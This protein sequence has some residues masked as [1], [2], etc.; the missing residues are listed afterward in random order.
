MIKTENLKPI[1]RD[2]AVRIIT[3]EIKSE[4]GLI[5]KTDKQNEDIKLFEV[6]SVSPKVTDVSVGDKVY[7]PWA[8]VTLPVSIDHNGKETRVG[9]TSEDE[10]MGVLEYD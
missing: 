2:I 8:R 1:N 10:V 6:I 5:I 9:F 7:I 4:S 3:D